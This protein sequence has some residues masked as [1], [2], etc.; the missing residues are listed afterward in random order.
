MSVLDKLSKAS[1][2]LKQGQAEPPETDLRP[3]A[4][5]AAEYK[6]ALLEA[7][8]DREKA[9]KGFVKKRRFKRLFRRK[10]STSQ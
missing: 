3:L 2:E 9:R 5:A 4:E 7:K 8:G 6:E 10:Q 1:A